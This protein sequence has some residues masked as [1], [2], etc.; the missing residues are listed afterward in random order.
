MALVGPLNVRFDLKNMWFGSK[1]DLIDLV[2]IA[3]KMDPQK[4]QITQMI[5]YYSVFSILYV[6]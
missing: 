3:M 2:R 5:Q 6:I 4:T 1:L